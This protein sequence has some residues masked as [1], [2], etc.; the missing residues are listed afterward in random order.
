MQA[1]PNGL[2]LIPLMVALASPTTG[3][4][5]RTNPMVNLCHEAAFWEDELRAIESG[6][7]WA[8]YRR[9]YVSDKLGAIIRNIP[10]QEV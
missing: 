6:A 1:N 9:D 5:R 10:D 8:S 4:T 7:G 3:S 2:L